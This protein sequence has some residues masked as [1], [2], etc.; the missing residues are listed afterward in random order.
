MTEEDVRIINLLTNCIVDYKYALV[1]QALLVKQM[2][3]LAMHSTGECEDYRNFIN[4]NCI[5]GQPQFCNILLLFI[6][7]ATSIVLVQ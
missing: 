3:Q 1:V 6:H 5:T 2:N 4:A 7:H